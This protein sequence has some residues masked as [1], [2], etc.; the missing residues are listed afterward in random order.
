MTK[1]AKKIKLGTAVQLRDLPT[2]LKPEIKRPTGHKHIYAKLR[3]KYYVV[4]PQ[5]LRRKKYHV[6]GRG[7]R[8]QGSG[9]VGEIIKS[10]SLGA[11]A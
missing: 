3:N 8:G 6:I 4:Q 7:P 1:H 2:H 10:K 9:P 5:A 11:K